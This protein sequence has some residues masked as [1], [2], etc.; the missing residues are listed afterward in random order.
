M[1]AFN[2]VRTS[3]TTAFVYLFSLLGLASTPVRAALGDPASTP[4]GATVRTLSGTMAQ[5][6][7]YT[8]AN[9]TTIDEYVATS[10]GKAFAYRWNG[11][12]QPDLDSILG[13]YAA[14]WRDTA[15]RAGEMRNARVTAAGVVV[16]TG[17]HMRGYA[18]RAWL[19]SALPAGM[20]EGDLQ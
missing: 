19:P 11:P 10:T 8:D 20:S 5:V 9:N 13:R 16:E 15:S 17:G 6:I 2:V 1:S 4:S 3:R 12:V 18:G 14:T 7:S